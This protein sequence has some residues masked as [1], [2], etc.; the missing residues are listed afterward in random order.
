VLSLARLAA[1]L[2]DESGIALV[3]A[4]GLMV[5]FGLTTAAM[6]EYT[7]AGSRTASTSRSYSVAQALAEAGLNDA[8][9]RLNDTASN[10]LSPTLLTPA[11]G[12]G[13]TCPDGV[14]T[15]FQ[16]AYQGGTTLWYGVLGAVAGEWTVT[17]W[18][19]TPNPTG[20]Q[21]VRR[22]MRATTVVVPNAMQPS[23]VPAWSYVYARATSN[24]TT[25]DVIVNEHAV[26]D[27]NF[28]ILGNLCLDNHGEIL[29]SNDANP[30]RVIV[31]GK[32]QLRNHGKVGASVSDRVS[33]AEVG[34]GCTSSIS[35][36]GHYCTAADDFFVDEYSQTPTVIDPPVADHV[37]WYAA[38]KPGP[39]FPCTTASGPAPTWDTDTTLNLATTGSAPT[40]NLTPGSDYTCRYVQNGAIVGELSWVASTRT[41]TVR[42]VMYYDGNMT[43]SGAV[44]VYDGGATIFLTGTLTTSNG[45]EF[46]AVKIGTECDFG[47]WNPNAEMLV[48][49]VNGGSA[50]NSVSFGNDTR[51][52][53]ALH[54][55][56]TIDLGNDT[57]VE[58]PMITERLSLG[59]HV[60]LVPLPDI[61]AVPVGTPGNPTTQATLTPPR[62]S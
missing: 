13:V 6:I 29:E 36:P 47:G 39:G 59:Q 3:V 15:C 5:V 34:G 48:F 58:G 4:L 33:R 37:G 60:E 55:K 44:N 26:V 28:Y 50:T 56:N 42:G 54:A 10:P 2:R 17:S 22:V 45:T 57:H 46:C 43:A 51:F 1:R 24:S 9:A 27:V 8:Q 52:Q 40:F 61:T 12:T 31:R 32:V 25:C 53:G 35:S 11:P 7:S 21:P 16:S 49:A 38:A 20:S 19:Q 41:L 18:G 14:N 30:V 23:S 62:Y